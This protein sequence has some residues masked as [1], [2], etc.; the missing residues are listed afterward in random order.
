MDGDDRVL[1]PGRQRRVACR[2]RTE[3]EAD[4]PRIDEQRCTVR[5]KHLQ[6]GVSGS[7]DGHRRHA[8]EQPIEL[9]GR[10][11]RQQRIGVGARRAVEA[12]EIQLAGGDPQRLGQRGKVV[13]LLLPEPAACPCDHPA[14]AMG[15]VAPAG[16]QALE[17]PAVGVSAHDPAA[18]P[19]QPGDHFTRLRPAGGEVAEADDLIDGADGHVGEDG[20]EGD[21]I[22]VD[23]ADEGDAG[24]TAPC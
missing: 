3:G 22:G 2:Q 4:A 1:G 20:V 8:G 24:H 19:A 12:E 17:Q 11:R 16:R 5:P 21:A 18:E 10:H 6:V 14:Q 15:L 23:V 7:E 9:H 13:V